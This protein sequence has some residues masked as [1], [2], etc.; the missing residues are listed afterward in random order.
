MQISELF[1]RLGFKIDGQDRFDKGV[2][3]LGIAQVRAI[4]LKHAVVGLGAAFSAMMYFAANAATGLYKFHLTTGL[5][6]KD[7]QNWQF[8]GAKA[9]VAAGEVTAA[10]KNIQD[11]QAEI[12]LGQGNVAPWALLGIDPRQ[13]PFRI[14]WLIHQRVKESAGMAPAMGRF[15]TSQMGISEEMFQFLRRDNLELGQLQEKFKQT[16]KAQRGLDE[17]SGKFNQM[18]YKIEQVGIALA[19]ELGPHVWNLLKQALPWIEKAADYLARM[20]ANT[21]EGE[22]MRAQFGMIAEGVM[23]AAVAF[24]ALGVALKS[25]ATLAAVVSVL[26]TLGFAGGAAATGGAASAAGGAAGGG[27]AATGGLLGALAVGIAPF[28]GAAV[29]QWAA[30]RAHDRAIQGGASEAD[31]TAIMNKMTPRQATADF[32]SAGAGQLK[33]L[34]GGYSYGKIGPQSSNTININQTINGAGNPAAVG[35]ESAS[36]IKTVVTNH[37]TGPFVDQTAIGGIAH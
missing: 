16:E 35:R 1:V 24:A 32:L 18:K 27:A 33:N 7:L 23:K 12:A 29:Y 28:L 10:I 36:A 4:N 5:S 17:L 21:P 26:K 19:A 22:R 20:A 9:N 14:L 3:Q 37:I 6:T 13:D 8:A 11:A 25:L 34:G 2:S 30:K 31:A 15:F